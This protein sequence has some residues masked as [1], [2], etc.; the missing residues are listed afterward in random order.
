MFYLTFL[1][2]QRHPDSKSNNIHNDDNMFNYITHKNTLH[3]H[4]ECAYA[5][6]CSRLWRKCWGTAKVAND[7]WVS[8]YFANIGR[9]CRY[10]PCRTGGCV[11][12]VVDCNQ[13]SLFTLL[14]FF[15][16][17]ELE[18]WIPLAGWIPTGNIRNIFQFDSESFSVIFIIGSFQLCYV[19]LKFFWVGA[20]NAVHEAFCGYPFNLFC[21]LSSA[22]H[23]FVRWSFIR[24]PKM[25]IHPDWTLL[26]PTFPTQE[27]RLAF[28]IWCKRPGHLR[29]LW[30]CS[31]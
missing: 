27:G 24:F 9:L 31:P 17:F 8:S 22:S 23:F 15:I 28:F 7:R 20:D 19:K 25:S 6:T 29:R 21:R 2:R 3:T 26:I 14:P 30:R 12:L 4:M 5:Y 10:V 13:S 18:P 11:G 16:F 1:Y